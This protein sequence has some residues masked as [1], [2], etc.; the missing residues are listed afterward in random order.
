MGGTN[1][2][3]S[4]NDLVKREQRRILGRAVLEANCDGAH[5]AAYHKELATWQRTPARWGGA[6]I[7][8]ETPQVA[9]RTRKHG[10]MHSS[11]D[12]QTT[13]RETWLGNLFTDLGLDDA[14]ALST[15]TALT[16]GC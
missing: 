10:S 14:D 1:R 9:G 13:D 5:D 8:T 16:A 2:S 12:I 4:L 7:V 3:G 11:E 6:H 15:R